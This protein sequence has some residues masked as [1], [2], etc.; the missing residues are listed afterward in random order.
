MTIPLLCR[1]IVVH[2]G[3]CFSTL[4]Q[5][6]SQYDVPGSTTYSVRVLTGRPDLV[7]LLSVTTNLRSSQVPTDS[8]TLIA[9]GSS[10]GSTLEELTLSPSTVAPHAFSSSLLSSFT[11]LITLRMTTWLSADAQSQKET[12]PSPD[13]LGK[14]RVL[15]LE[16]ADRNLWAMVVPFAYV[17]ALSCLLMLRSCSL[18]NLEHVISGAVAHGGELPTFLDKHGYKIK[19][20]KVWSLSGLDIRVCSSVDSIEMMDVRLL[21]I[22]G[23][24]S[25]THY[26]SNSIAL[27]PFPRSTTA[28]RQCARSNSIGCRCGSSTTPLRRN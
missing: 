6:M 2:K 24:R 4:L 23:Q 20:L 14:L 12:S 27:A 22:S 25:W 9:L 5:Y 19:S 18:P 21:T 7:S 15:D 16:R 13:A 1:H 10:A 3:V 11:N 26:D 28:I 17:G 8:A